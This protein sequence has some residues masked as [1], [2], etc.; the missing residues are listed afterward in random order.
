MTGPIHVL[1]VEDD[2]F[3]AKILA[4]SIEDGLV[5]RGFP[6]GD[7][8]VR[9]A[10]DVGTALDWLGS[11]TPNVVLLDLHLGTAKGETLIGPIRRIR[12]QARIIVLSGDVD[13]MAR[14]RLADSVIVKGMPSLA[15]IMAEI[16]DP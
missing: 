14:G 8:K 6:R 1:I 12:P 9:A 2:P 3:P 11:R 5:A 7:V 16:P 10:H 13:A 15:E 4:E